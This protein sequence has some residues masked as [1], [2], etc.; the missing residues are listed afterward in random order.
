MAPRDFCFVHRQKTR[1]ICKWL[2]HFSLTLPRLLIFSH[3]DDQSGGGGNV[4][5]VDSAT[6]K[7]VACY[8]SRGDRVSVDFL[9]MPHTAH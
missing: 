7:T 8:I 9:R 1:L 4:E 5:N 3:D 6:K 2:G